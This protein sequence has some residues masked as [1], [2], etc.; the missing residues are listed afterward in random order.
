MFDHVS[1]GVTDL[2][3]AGRFYDAVLQPLG[4]RRLY[5]GAETIAYG[6]KHPQLWLSKSQRPVPADMKNGLHFC[7][8]AP[9]RAAVDAFHAIALQNGGR[10]NGQ[11]GLRPEYTPTY[12]A[13][14]IIDPDGYRIEAVCYAP[15]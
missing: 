8:T 6:D 11:P 7:F 15:E 2:A 4:F 1:Y 12:Y 14:F 9:T 5:D 13:G 10:D 3:A